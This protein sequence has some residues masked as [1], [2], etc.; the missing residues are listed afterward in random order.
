MAKF[1]P[2][3]TVADFDRLFPTDEACKAYLAARRWP[4]G[5]RCPRCDNDKVWTL[6]ARA[7]H[8]VCPKCGPRDYRF[9]VTVGTPFENTNVGLQKWFKV[10]Y[11][12]LTGKKGVSSL[13]IQRVMGFGSYETALYMTHRIR[14]ALVDPEFRKLIGIVEVDETL[15]RRKKQEPARRQE[16]GRLRGRQQVPGDRRRHPQGH[17]GC[18]RARQH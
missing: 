2:Q 1:T 16:A 10:I 12:M 11:M 7:F 18:P 5:V 3:M 17:I 14:T 8:Y 15:C 13:E 6:K 9:S 4:E